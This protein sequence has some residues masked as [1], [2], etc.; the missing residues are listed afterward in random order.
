MI[1]SETHLFFN[2]ETGEFEYYIDPI[3]SGIEDDTEKFEDDIWI[4]APC[5]RDLNEYEIMTDYAD[6]VTDPRANELLCVALEGKG[7]FQRFK[8]T[9][10]RVGLN[11]EWFAFKRDA[12]IDIAREWCEE[13]DIPYADL[14]PKERPPRRAIDRCSL[15][16]IVIPFHERCA[17]GAAEVLRDTLYYSKSDAEQEIRRMMKKPR[18]AYA[19]I[20]DNR[21]IGI[22]GA[23]PQYGVTGWELHPLAVMKEY[24]RLGVGSTLVESLEQEVAGRGGIML[25]LGSDDETGTTSLYGTDLYE[26]TFGKI[27]NIKNIGGHPYPF[28][29]KIGYKIVGV[30]PDANGM[31]KPDIWMAKRIR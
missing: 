29:E 27:T 19:A 8:D 23:I 26:D 22:I 18:V 9:I 6:T 31:G 25:Y 20:A 7:A 10:Y 17:A 11:D 13:N 3:Y 28:Y 16:M 24:Q 30:L 5:Q 12:Y 2:I 1:D 14:K 15:D 4:A 21:V